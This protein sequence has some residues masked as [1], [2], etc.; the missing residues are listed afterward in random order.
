[1]NDEIKKL[2][3]RITEL[4]NEISRNNFVGFQSFGKYC[5]FT[6]RIKVPVYSTLPG[7]A[8]TGELV[9]VNGVLWVASAINTWTCVGEQTA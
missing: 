5:D 9:V 4:E 6:D 2:N 1:M 3:L 7:T 8:R